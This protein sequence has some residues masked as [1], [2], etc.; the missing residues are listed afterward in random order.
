MTS[1]RADWTLEIPI[2][3]VQLIW[4]HF[5]RLSMGSHYRNELRP[6][7]M[8]RQIYRDWNASFC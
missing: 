4:A 8:K 7:K 2:G 5:A 3:Q 1:R 6:C